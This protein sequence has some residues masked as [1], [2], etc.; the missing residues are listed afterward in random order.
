MTKHEKSKARRAAFGPFWEA[1]YHRPVTEVRLTRWGY[2]P[3]CTW[4]RST[5][6][7]VGAMFPLE[8]GA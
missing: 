4:V 8:I 5:V 6:Q 7:P 3:V 2:R 1:T